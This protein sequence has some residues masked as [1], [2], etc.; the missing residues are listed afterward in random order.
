MK[1]LSVDPAQYGT[2][3]TTWIASDHSGWS[4]QVLRASGLTLWEVAAFTVTLSAH[5]EID[6]VLV[7]SRG[8]GG[9]VTDMLRNW[10]A[11]HAQVVE[12]RP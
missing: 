12:V 5:Y 2:E 7:D 9:A 11:F 8:V 10:D 1:S 3:Y 4:H 6:R